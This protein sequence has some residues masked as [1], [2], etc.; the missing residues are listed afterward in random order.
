MGSTKSALEIR[1]LRA[2]EREIEPNKTEDFEVRL[3]PTLF[4]SFIFEL[5]LGYVC[6]PQIFRGIEPH[7]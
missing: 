2:I 7:E 1:I 3:Y 4:S 6:V 5:S